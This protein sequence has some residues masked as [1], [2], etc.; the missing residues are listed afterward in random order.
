MKL[1]IRAKG[2]GEMGPLVNKGL[3]RFRRGGVEVR[4]SDRW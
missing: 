4:C 1:E 3:P 2:R